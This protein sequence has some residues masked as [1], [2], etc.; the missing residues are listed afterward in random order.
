V[1]CNFATILKVRLSSRIVGVNKYASWA[2]DLETCDELHLRGDEAPSYGI[3]ACR[4]GDRS[5]KWGNAQAGNEA[6][7]KSRWRSAPHMRARS[8]EDLLLYAAH[9]VIE[10]P[11]HC[12]GTNDAR[13]GASS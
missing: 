4:L 9:R 6:L 11:C 7:L 12:A 8:G 13:S 3:N 2:T 10:A 5:L 1:R